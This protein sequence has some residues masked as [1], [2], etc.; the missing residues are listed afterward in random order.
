MFELAQVMIYVLTPISAW[1]AAGSLKFVVNSIRAGRLAFHQIGYGGMPSNHSAI[2]AST[3]AMVAWQEGIKSGAFGAAFTLAFVVLMDA[4]HLRR[5]VGLHAQGI[6]RLAVGDSRHLPLRERMGHTRLEIL[7][8][9]AVGV[10]V[11][12]AL[13]V[14]LR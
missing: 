10:A 6:N 7:A 11:A 14:L 13:H 4:N 1:L 12:S 5:Q 8:G 3:A 2:V 9:I